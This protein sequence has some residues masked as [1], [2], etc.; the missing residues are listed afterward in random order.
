MCETKKGKKDLNKH[1]VIFCSCWCEHLFAALQLGMVLMSVPVLAGYDVILAATVLTCEVSA[2]VLLCLHPHCLHQE[3]SW[4]P[5]APIWH[6]SSCRARRLPWSTRRYWWSG[7]LFYCFYNSTVM[8]WVGVGR[9][10]WLHGVNCTSEAQKR[11]GMRGVIINHKFAY[12]NMS[13]LVLSS[14]A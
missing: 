14:L 10:A 1:R 9:W 3:L 7:N 5:A 11:D 12:V 8:S 4:G 13:S 6:F 2:L